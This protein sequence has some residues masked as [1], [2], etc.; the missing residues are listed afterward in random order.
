MPAPRVVSRPIELPTVSH[1]SRDTRGSV[2]TGLS[3]ASGR[4]AASGGSA[5]SERSIASIDSAATIESVQTL[6]NL[7]RQ[8]SLDLQSNEALAAV[9]KAH[10]K[11]LDAADYQRAPWVEE[12]QDAYTEYKEKAIN[13]GNA[14]QEF[15]R[16]LRATGST[17]TPEEH[18][19]RARLAVTWG[20]LSVIAAEGRLRFIQTYDSVY[21]DPSSVNT[22]VD[23]GEDSIRSGRNAVK[24]ARKNYDML[25]ERVNLSADP[26][27]FR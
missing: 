2:R 25:F 18:V 24:Q 3:Q 9:L 5:A 6:R 21:R 17:A 27:I 22:H 7:I 15:Q 8:I 14:H 13:A 23:A 26:A 12:V 19:K 1:Y 20:E 10:A 11:T 4:S 16:Y